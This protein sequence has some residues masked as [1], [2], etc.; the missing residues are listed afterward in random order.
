[1]AIEAAV[2]EA[3]VPHQIADARTFA[4]A[5]TKPTGRRPDDSLPG[6]L[7]VFG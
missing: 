3:K 6:L 7:F 1:V 5:A 2:R 4:A